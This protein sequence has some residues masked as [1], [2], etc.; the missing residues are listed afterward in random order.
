MNS[1]FAT[2]DDELFATLGDESESGRN[3]A[4]EFKNNFE[5][6]SW[7]NDRIVTLKA[8]PCMY[9]AQFWLRFFFALRCAPG[10]KTPELDYVCI[11]SKASAHV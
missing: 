2:L 8:T 9:I 7:Q 4:P 11:L 6:G 10:E 3:K 5:N 1:L